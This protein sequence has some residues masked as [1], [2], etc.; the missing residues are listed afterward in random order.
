MDGYAVFEEL[1]RTNVYR[2]EVSEK[3]KKKIFLSVWHKSV[4]T[5]RDDFGP[6][7]ISTDGTVGFGY[8]V[9]EF[10]KYSPRIPKNSK[11]GEHIAQLLLGIL[12][13]GDRSLVGVHRTMPNPDILWI[14]CK[15][16]LVEITGIAE[17][18]ASS[19][20]AQQSRKQI[21]FQDTSI[22][23]I[24]MHIEDE[25]KS[26]S[27]HRFFKTRKFAIREPLQKILIVP[28][29]QELYLSSRLLKGWQCA[30]LEFSYNELIF[31]AQKLWPQFRPERVFQQNG[32]LALFE[33]NFLE[34]FFEIWR[35]K[36]NSICR[37]DDTPYRE[38]ILFACATKRFPVENKEIELVER[39][40]KNWECDFRSHPEKM[41]IEH[42]LN[43]WETQFMDIYREPGK[44]ARPI[45][46]FL[47]LLRAFSLQLIKY[48]KKIEAMDPFD[49]LDFKIEFSA[50]R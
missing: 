17:I 37:L 27:A 35:H 50:Y 6:T 4:D 29:G 24:L 26:G 21:E 38:L 18:K 28:A 30:E 15:G 40:M 11:A 48:Q 44:S 43:A 13:T 1:K 33:K 2:E 20:A 3:I 10:T 25:K 42:E 23:R 41:L 49:I 8:L 22:R 14:K 36:T 5:L 47:S 12:H 7:G 31:M 39:L 45:I 16:H 46:F 34:P 9:E 19:I 32:I